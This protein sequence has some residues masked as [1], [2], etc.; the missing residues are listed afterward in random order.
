MSK[1]HCIPQ[2]EPSMANKSDLRRIL[3]AFLQVLPSR[4][5]LGTYHPVEG[6]IDQEPTIKL[7][8]SP[9]FQPPMVGNLLSERRNLLSFR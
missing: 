9:E 5:L 2:P 4:I 1:I 6:P 3:H 8:I 7:Q